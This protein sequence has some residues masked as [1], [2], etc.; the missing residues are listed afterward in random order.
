MQLRAAGGEEGE[1]SWPQSK[2]RGKPPPAMLVNP[3]CSS[4]SLLKATQLLLVPCRNSVE[5]PGTMA[6]ASS[7]MDVFALLP[8]EG[9]WQ[10]TFCTGD[11]GTEELNP[12][13]EIL[14]P[15]WR[16]MQLEVPIPGPHAAPYPAGA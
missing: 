15:V 16:G 9:N 11:W 10:V 13:F 4:V 12:Y 8:R 3:A 14:F 5:L 1:R 6:K 7:A 2:A